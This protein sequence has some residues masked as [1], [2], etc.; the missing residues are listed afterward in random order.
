MA[1]IDQP[2]VSYAVRPRP[3]VGESLAGFVLRVA[4]RNGYTTESQ[5]LTSLQHRKQP[6]FKEFCERLSLSDTERSRL[7]GALPR[8]WG[9]DIMGVVLSVR[10]FNH[11]SVRWCPRC[12]DE[13]GFLN[14]RWDLKLVCACVHHSI[15][16]HESCGRCGR[17]Q[18]RATVIAGHCECG[19]SLADGSGSPAPPHVVD[20]THAL[21][22]DGGMKL[23]TKSPPASALVAN[24]LVRYLGQFSTR[25]QP[26]RPGQV[27]GLDRLAV[28]SAVV[29]GTAA[30]LKDW[31]T[32]FHALLSAMQST[33]A[34][35]PSLR[36]SFSPLYRVLYVDLSDPWFQFMRDAFE[37]YLREHWWGLVCKRNRLL[38]RKAVEAHPRLSTRQATDT[39]GLTTAVIRH[40]AQTELLPSA[41]A[42]LPSGRCVRTIGSEDLERATMA[43][44][45]GLNLGQ[46][47]E[48]LG[49]PEGRLRELVA[50]NVVVPLIAKSGRQR[51]AAWMFS[52]AEIGRLT[53]T[54][55]APSSETVI[56]V[57]HILR[58]WHLRQSEPAE[59]ATAVL[60]GDLSAQG[61]GHTRVGL[62]NVLLNPLAVRGWLNTRRSASEATVSINEAAKTL[63]VKQQVGYA[64]A[65]MGL[66]R[67]TT[68]HCGDHRVVA[69]VEIDRFRRTFVSLAELASQAGRLPRVALKELDAIPICG[70]AIDGSRQYFYRR[71]DVSRIDLT[72]GIAARGQRAAVVQSRPGLLLTIAAPVRQAPDA[73]SDAVPVAEDV[74]CSIPHRTC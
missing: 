59:L 74:H 69:R 55:D 44:A 34:Q 14:G 25:A 58:Y 46:A 70:P 33:A 21:G 57:R 18:T 71:A 4:Q 6:A 48:R 37:D 51:P 38:Q 66:L 64:L 54:P 16:L 43:A 1:D 22:G 30:L 8:R 2:R 42:L 39:S 68:A 53:L 5:L 47:S 36:R 9:A 52:K 60:I 13:K 41:V 65:R 31:P 24:L 49:L 10:D 40:M 61:D 29:S 15:W 50:A 32:G 63:G 19:S 62:G 17:R 7:F 67:T 20:L 73:P 27:V 35:S 26:S 11:E 72:T 56:P 3:N 12:L 23:T 45:G 28:A